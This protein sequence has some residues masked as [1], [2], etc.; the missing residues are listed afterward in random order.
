MSD[1]ISTE[2][3]EALT[4]QAS[5]AADLAYLDVWQDGL[6]SAEITRIQIRAA[7]LNLLSNGLIEA[8]SL[9]EIDRIFANGVTMR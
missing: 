8:K 7:L 2:V 9:D 5:M 1:S 3:L 6:T 4:Q